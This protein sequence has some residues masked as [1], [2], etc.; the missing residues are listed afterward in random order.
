MIGKSQIVGA[1][2]GHSSNPHD[3]LKKHPQEPA[4][5][6]KNIEDLKTCFSPDSSLL[7]YYPTV[8]SK[9]RDDTAIEV[10]TYFKNSV[11]LFEKPSHNTLSD[12]K[13]FEKRL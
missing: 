1:M 6:L 4:I 9:K 8:P 10:L 13:G 5:A 12:A 7:F 11:M 2:A 3:F